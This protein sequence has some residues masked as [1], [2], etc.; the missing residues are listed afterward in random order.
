MW[1]AAS[2]RS[3]LHLR[4]RLLATLAA[5]TGLLAPAAVAGQGLSAGQAPAAPNRLVVVGASTSSITLSWKAS[6]GAVEYE[7]RTRLE[8][9]GLSSTRYPERVAKTKGTRITVGSVRCGTSFTVGIAARG[10][11]TLSREKRIRASTKTCAPPAPADPTPAAPPPVTPAP[12]PDLQPPSVPIAFTST[13]STPSSVSVSWAP[14]T[15]NVAVA[16]YGLYLNGTLVSST[17]GTSFVF[18]S[19]E[20]GQSPRLGVDAFDAAGNRSARTEATVPTPACATPQTSCNKVALPGE[21]T[22]QALLASLSPG[23]VGC[24]R[25]G[26]YTPSGLYVLD[27]SS[28]NVTIMAYPDDRAVLVGTIVVRRGASGSRLAG[29]AVEGTGGSTGQQ[30]TIQVLAA[31]DFVIEDSDIT[32]AWRGRS[33]VILGN[34]QDDVAVR[35]VIRRNRFHECGNP[36]NGNLDHAIYAA[37]VVD[38]RI[39]DNIFWN[40]AAYALHLYPNAQRTVFAHNVIDGGSRSV[41]GVIFAGDSGAASSGNIVEHNVI[42]YSTRY[43]IESW[44]AGPVGSGNVA[45]SNCVFGGGLGDIGV[46]NGFAAESNVP[47]DPIFLSRAGRDYRLRADSPCLAVVGYDTAARLG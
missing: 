8:R 40:T 47:A 22:A 36:A 44:W 12:S 46:T 43:N 23:Q 9:K 33:C 11:R 15:D 16:G 19:L 18:G 45:R 38:A 30:N 7:V 29:V 1:K 32:N 6:K 21:G 35:P 41:G 42:G 25:G 20:C 14:S 31:S 5:A 3:R 39:T 4:P 34:S 27:F 26:T 28:A 13:G 10:K 37:D 24:L 2:T 17:T